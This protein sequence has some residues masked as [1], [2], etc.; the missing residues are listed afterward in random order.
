MVSPF[1]PSHNS[2]LCGS[3]NAHYASPGFPLPRSGGSVAGQRRRSRR[4]SLSRPAR[5]L[6]GDPMMLSLV[7]CDHCRA[8]L[9]LLD[10][11]AEHTRCQMCRESMPLV[12]SA[13]EVVDG[14]PHSLTFTAP[15]PGVYTINVA[16]SIPSY[17][18]IDMRCPTCN[19]KP[20]AECDRRTMGSRWMY[21]RARVN[22]A[23]ARY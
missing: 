1:T 19:A 14:V 6:R 21:H 20:G 11:N 18:P 5:C 22:A 16:P 8:F 7:Q 13:K 9:S 10:F 2:A 4:G 15:S 3:C 17:Q 12:I 23:V